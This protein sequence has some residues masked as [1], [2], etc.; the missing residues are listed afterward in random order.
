MKKI[1]NIILGWWFW[2]TNR[3]NELAKS[4]LKVCADCSFRVGFT[5]GEC[6]CVLQAKARLYDEECPLG[7]W[8]K[9]PE[10]KCNYKHSDLGNYPYPK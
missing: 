3:N 2:V 4:R 9:P 8:S 5:C 1:I 10:S 6:G 7:M